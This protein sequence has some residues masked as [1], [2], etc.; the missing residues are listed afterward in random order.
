[1]LDQALGQPP[2]LL[3]CCHHRH[4]MLPQAF[5]AGAEDWFSCMAPGYHVPWP[6]AI[7]IY[8][9]GASPILTIPQ[10]LIWCFGHLYH[11]YQ[12]IRTYFEI[13]QFQ[14]DSLNLEMLMFFLSESAKG[15]IDLSSLQWGEGI[16]WC[17]SLQDVVPWLGKLPSD[18]TPFE[19]FLKERDLHHDSVMCQP[20]HTNIVS[21]KGWKG[22][23]IRMCLIE[24]TGAKIAL[25][26]W[27]RLCY[28][29]GIQVICMLAWVLSEETLTMVL[30]CEIVFGHLAWVL[31]STFK[32]WLSSEVFVIR[33][34]NFLK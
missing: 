33:K 13:W 2:S 6:W 16:G 21:T 17:S 3:R 19:S 18:S 11:L 26:T 12:A 27:R 23:M 4:G 29:Q 34:L 28:D 8:L 31:G 32:W 1:M 7:T 25:T 24:S 20:H 5:G 22:C 30:A 10:D 14:L 15:S 9:R